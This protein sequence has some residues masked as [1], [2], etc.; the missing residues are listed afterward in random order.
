MSKKFAV[1]FAA[2]ESRR[3]GT[4]R[5]GVSMANDYIPIPRGDAGM[6]FFG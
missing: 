1:T 2:E 6:R 4:G 3:A 5:A